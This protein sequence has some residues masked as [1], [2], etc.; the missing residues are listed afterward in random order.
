MKHEHAQSI[1]RN[2]AVKAA[3]IGLGLAYL[4][5]AGIDGNPGWLGRLP[6]WWPNLAVATVLMY[7]C[8]YVYGGWAGAAILEKKKDAGWVGT[9]YAVW[10][11]LTVAFFSSWVGFFQEGLAKVGMNDNPFVAYIAAQLFW[12][13]VGGFLPAALVGLWFGNSVKRA[14][15]H[16]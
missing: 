9:I 4:I 13:A 6:R 3:T 7:L 12:V 2:Q 10:A 14:G 5:M 1:G 15:K 16:A 8:A 11:L